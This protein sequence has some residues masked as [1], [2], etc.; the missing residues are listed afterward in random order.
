MVYKKRPGPIGKAVRDRDRLNA[1]QTLAERV[2]DDIDT[3]DSLRDV[4]SLA[5]VLTD[6]LDRL[7]AGG[8]GIQDDEGRTLDELATRRADRRTNPASG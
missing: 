3:S 1:L 8:T 7:A 2:A 6:T 4:A 5:R